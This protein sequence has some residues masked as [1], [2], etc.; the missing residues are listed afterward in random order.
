MILLLIAIMAQITHKANIMTAL[1]NAVMPKIIHKELI[2]F[3]FP[4]ILLSL[5]NVSQESC[6]CTV[7]NMSTLGIYLIYN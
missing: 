3:Y 5:V 6:V 2:S 7:E 1:L 4:C